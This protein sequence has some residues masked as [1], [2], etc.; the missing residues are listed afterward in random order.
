MS[1][2]TCLLLFIVFL[3]LLPSALCFAASSSSPKRIAIL[4]VIRQAPALYQP[5]L[6][7]T[8]A[9]LLK[10]ELHV[11]L[12]GTLQAVEYIN[13]DE[14]HAA[15]ED[16][17]YDNTALQNPKNL[18]CLAEK[19]S[20]DLVV[21]LLITDAEEFQY[22][23]GWDHTL[24]LRSTAELQLTGWN[25]ADDF[26]FS[27][28]KRQSYHDEYTLAGTVPELAKEACWRLFKKAKLKD[29]IFPLSKNA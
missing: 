14:I 27:L 21:C 25:R 18:K 9:Q 8:L 24:I 23:A 19:L 2:K 26:I 7:I 4:P 1:K 11:P 22:Y 10:K 13:P 15:I 5:Q 16:L 28:K 20:A 17:R 3:S 6:E 12:N 29:F